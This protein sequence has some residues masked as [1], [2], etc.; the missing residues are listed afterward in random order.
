MPNAKAGSLVSGGRIVVY[1]GKA[2]RNRRASSWPHC[3]GPTLPEQWDFNSSLQRFP[4]GEWGRQWQF[5]PVFLSENALDKGSLAGYSLWV[6]E[7]E[8]LG[9]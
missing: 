2:T 6:A 4:V 9:D 5:T 1:G 3:D 8:R 7:L